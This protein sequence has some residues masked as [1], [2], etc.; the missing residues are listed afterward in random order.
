MIYIFV[1]KVILNFWHQGWD[2]VTT[3]CTMSTPP[4]PFMD[5]NNN[6]CLS[7]AIG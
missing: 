6:M 5:N 3:Y 2:Y 1:P 7:M 4:I